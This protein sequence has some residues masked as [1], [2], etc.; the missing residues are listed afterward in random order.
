MTNIPQRMQIK[1]NVSQGDKDQD[2]YK[3]VF[4]N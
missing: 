3:K 1:F 2:K 4:K